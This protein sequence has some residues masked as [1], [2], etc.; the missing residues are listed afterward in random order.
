MKLMSTTSLLIRLWHQ[1]LKSQFGTFASFVEKFDY[2]KDLGV[3]HVQLLPVL[4][5]YHVNELKNSERLLEYASSNSNYNWGY[6]PQ[7]YFALTGMYSTDPSNPQNELKNSRIWS[8]KFTSVEW[9]SCLTLSI[10]IQLMWTSLRYRAKLLPFHGCGRYTSD[11]LWWWTLG[12]N[13]LHVQT[14]LGRFN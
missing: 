11:K 14:S 6:D 2:L 1:E 8:M 10:T 9:E 4:S 5:Y 13:P 3:T 12:N 7:N